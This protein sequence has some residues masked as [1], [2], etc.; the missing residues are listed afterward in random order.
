MK[1]ASIFVAT[2]TLSASVFG[3][4][5][6]VTADVKGR[7]GRSTNTMV[8]K[9]FTSG[10]RVSII[11][12]A[13]GESIFGNVIWDKVSINP[14]IY[15]S[16]YYVKTGV[17]GYLP[18]VPQCPTPTCL[19]TAGSGPKSGSCIPASYTSLTPKTSS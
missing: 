17:S 19:E 4:T 14:D 15:V 10:T 7:A 11:C 6:P 1:L 12:Q 5:Y 18:G 3:A 9:T 2:C 16:D 13:A 8:L